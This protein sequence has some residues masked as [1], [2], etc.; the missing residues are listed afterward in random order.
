MVRNLDADNP[1]LCLVLLTHC[2]FPFYSIPLLVTPVAFFRALLVKGSHG[3]V[4][5]PI[6]C[7]N[8][9][10]VSNCCPRISIQLTCKHQLVPKCKHHTSSH[11]P[12]CLSP[13]QKKKKPNSGTI[14]LH[15]LPQCKASLY[16]ISPARNLR[17]T[18]HTSFNLTTRVG[19]S[20]PINFTCCQE[21]MWI[22][23]VSGWSGLSEQNL[24]ASWV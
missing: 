7:R 10:L 5:S 20:H 11:E 13:T 16:T 24:L 21:T 23:H 18:L 4:C 1:R 19:E 12:P 17:V 2:V 9:D 15:L 14:I 6:C 22:F 3:C 8:S